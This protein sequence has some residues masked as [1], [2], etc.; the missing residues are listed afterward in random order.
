MFRYF[1]W[2]TPRNFLVSSLGNISIVA[3]DKRCVAAVAVMWNLKSRHVSS[4][5]VKTCSANV[6]PSPNLR[7]LLFFARL[8]KLPRSSAK[9]FC[10]RDLLLILL[11]FF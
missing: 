6:F 4:L 9:T 5:F 2:R 7:N 11:S 10:E 3:L 1:A 8:K